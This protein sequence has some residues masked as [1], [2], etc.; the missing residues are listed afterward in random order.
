MAPLSRHYTAFVLFQERSFGYC[1]CPFVDSDQPER[2]MARVVLWVTDVFHPL[3]NVTVGFSGVGGISNHTRAQLFRFFIY[4][5]SILKRVFE[6]ILYVRSAFTY[7]FRSAR[8]LLRIRQFFLGARVEKEWR[9]S[10]EIESLIINNTHKSDLEYQQ[11]THFRNIAILKLVHWTCYL[12][13]HKMTSSSC[14]WC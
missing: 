10:L 8:T 6:I 2:L 11:M 14:N 12:P 13:D 1:W 4:R 5:Y 7:F 9:P 3:L